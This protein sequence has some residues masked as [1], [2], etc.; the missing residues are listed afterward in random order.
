MNLRRGTPGDLDALTAMQR[1][2]YARNEAILGVVPIPLQIDYADV[3]ASKEVWLADGDARLR[4]ALILDLE[5]DH[6]LIWSIATDPREQQSGLGKRLLAAAEARARELSFT[7]IRLYT[8]TLLVHLVAWYGRHGYAV[9][10]IEQR[11]DRSIT[12]MIKTLA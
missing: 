8:G 2:A 5:P 7:T 12:H 11:P 1:A 3:L 4:G 6:L 10:R 9:E